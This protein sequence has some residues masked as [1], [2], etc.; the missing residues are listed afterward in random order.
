MET[1][2]KKKK[3]S[4]RKDRVGI[5]ELLQV[6]RE[7]RMALVV[8]YHVALEQKIHILPS[9]NAIFNLLDPESTLG[10]SVLRFNG[11]FDYLIGRQIPILSENTSW[12]SMGYDEYCAGRIFVSIFSSFKRTKQGDRREIR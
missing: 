6:Q 12:D 4:D 8:T 3:N 11:F 7:V 2:K 10:W 5:P 1:G 9:L